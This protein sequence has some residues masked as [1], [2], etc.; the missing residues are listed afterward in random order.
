MEI[1]NTYML[2]AG[3]L[4][5]CEYVLVYNTESFSKRANDLYV[6]GI[7][8]SKSNFLPL[9]SKTPD[10]RGIHE[11]VEKILRIT[12]VNLYIMYQK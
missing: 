7:S 11:A 6:D 12:R 9:L 8:I 1:Y 4:V 3:K 10:K 2:G 5:D